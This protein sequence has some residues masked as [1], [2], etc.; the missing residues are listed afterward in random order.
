M[1][2][3][4]DHPGATSEDFLNEI[5]RKVSNR[6]WTVLHVE[7]E[8]APYA[9]TIGLH[10][11]GLPELLATGVSPPRGSVLLDY[12]AEE[13]LLDGPLVPGQRISLHVDALIEIVE[14]EHPDAHMGLGVAY[15]GPDV[16]ALQLVWTDGRGR[17]PWAAG[18][19]GVDGR[20]PVLG[21]RGPQNA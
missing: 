11:F 19:D 15:D 7:E 5:H 3:Q 18:F 20:Q 1:C 4:C 6:G 10:A 9:Y 21:K 14:V 8:R 2:W 13:S 12:F 17:W 16:Q